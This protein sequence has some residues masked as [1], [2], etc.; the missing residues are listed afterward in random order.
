[1]HLV[2]HPWTVRGVVN[3]GSEHRTA[4][5]VEPKPHRD[6]V[7]ESLGELAVFRSADIG[8]LQA[9]VASGQSVRLDTGATATAPVGGLAVLLRG[10]ATMHG[11]TGEIR[12]VTAGDVVGATALQGDGAG[13]AMIN[14]LEPVEL[15]VLTPEALAPFALA[16]RSSSAALDVPDQAKTLV[17]ATITRPGGLGALH[18]GAA[19]S[20]LA[21]AAMPAA[22]GSNVRATVSVPTP[23]S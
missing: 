22:S 2:A 8:A 15:L 13:V 21:L 19:R 16:Y 9:L 3:G 6:K 5:L 14:T 12:E 4:G 7:V 17:R 23:R 1:M 18:A 10:R 11:S 20:T